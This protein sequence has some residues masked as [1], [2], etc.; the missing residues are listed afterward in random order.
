MRSSVGIALAAITVVLTGLAVP[1]LA[2]SPT[3]KCM[4]GKRHYYVRMPEGHNGKT[5]VGAIVYAHGYRGT[6]KAVMGNKWFR[7][8]GNRLG[9]AFIA[10]KSSG[11][12][13]SLPNSPMRMRGEPAVDE[14]AY[15]DRVLADATTRFA[16]DPKRIMMTG[17]SAGGMMVWNLACHRSNK[18][19]GFVPI[20]G[21]FWRPVPQKCTTPPS[22][23][24]HLHGDRD[25]IVPL[26]GR[27]IR[28]THQGDVFK[29]ISMYAEY[30]Q[31]GPPKNVSRGKLRCQARRSGSGNILEFC[32]YNGSHTF[33]STY[34]RQA[35]DLLRESG[36]L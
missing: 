13:W 14:L 18:F 35:W 29:A 16:I 21:T 10:P 23:V 17:F 32:L 20:A 34:I 25:K 22:N 27:P 7:Q 5:K 30:G 24:I 19:A 36:K 2:C 11:G 12:D 26:R 9:V 3:T 33:D 31:F 15:F 28:P 1:T 8:L 4:L 6:A